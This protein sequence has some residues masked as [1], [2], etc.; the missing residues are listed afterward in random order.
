MGLVCRLEG[1]LIPFERWSALYDEM[2]SECK[3]VV[4]S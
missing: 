1:S 4:D 2:S 3:E